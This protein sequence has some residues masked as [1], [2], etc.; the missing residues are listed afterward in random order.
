MI[1]TTTAAPRWPSGSRNCPAAASQLPPDHRARPRRPRPWPPVP[2]SHLPGRRVSRCRVRPR[3][4]PRRRVAACANQR[5]VVP[6]IDPLTSTGADQQ[7]EAEQQFHRGGRLAAGAQQARTVAGVDGAGAATASGAGQQ[8]AAAARRAA[9]PAGPLGRAQRGRVLV[10]ERV[11]VAGAP[12]RSAHPPR[13]PRR[14]ASGVEAGQRARHPSQVLER[15]GAA[16]NRLFGRAAKRAR[17]DL[18][19]VVQVRAEHRDR[20]SRAS[21]RPVRVEHHRRRTASAIQFQARPRG[22]PVS[23]AGPTSVRT[24]SSRYQ[25]PPA[26]AQQDPSLA[27]CPSV[28]GSPARRRRGGRDICGLAARAEH[29]RRRPGRPGAPSATS[30]WPSPRSPPIPW[31]LGQVSRTHQRVRGE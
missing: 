26:G 24:R 31:R 17:V 25:L 19:Q 27:S 18:R 28:P 21:C 11:H 10:P 20:P 12:S 22:R 29:R 4:A 7:A 1:T 16:G 13:C 14:P 5:R 9:G 3:S 30:A 15:P 23:A 2:A 6:L 8:L